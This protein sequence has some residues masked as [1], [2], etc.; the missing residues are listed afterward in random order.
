MGCPSQKVGGTMNNPL[1]NNALISARQRMA[2]DGGINLNGADMPNGGVQTKFS[3]RLNPPWA[4]YME[5]IW[6]M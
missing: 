2:L 4:G 1:F 5:K 3:P 6:I